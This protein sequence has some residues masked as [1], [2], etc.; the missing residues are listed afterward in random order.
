[1]SVLLT[2][3][4]NA[5]LDKGTL[6]LHCNREFVCETWVLNPT[7]V[8]IAGER[9]PAGRLNP[10]ISLLLDWLGFK[11][12]KVTIPKWIQRGAMDPADLLFS[13]LVQ[14]ILT[15]SARKKTQE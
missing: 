15:F 7:L 4:G 1:M 9:W 14:A 10:H 3:A 13:K 11:E 5:P 8:L 6:N 2:I 12:A